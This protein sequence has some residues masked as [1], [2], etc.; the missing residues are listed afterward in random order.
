[1]KSITSSSNEDDQVHGEV[2]NENID[3]TQLGYREML[4]R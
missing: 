2:K 4:I 1:M 3:M